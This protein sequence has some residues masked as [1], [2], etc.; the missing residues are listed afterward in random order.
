M[1]Q[2][3]VQSMASLGKNS[4]DDETDSAQDPGEYQSE[5]GKQSDLV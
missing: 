3:Q 1:D 4:A 2:T 5:E